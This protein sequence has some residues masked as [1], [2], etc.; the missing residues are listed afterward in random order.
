MFT[1]IPSS[2]NNLMLRFTRGVRP[3]ECIPFLS[4]VAEGYFVKSYEKQE[5]VPKKALHIFG[6]DQSAQPS[7]FRLSGACRGHYTHITY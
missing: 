1:C 2:A 4:V 3:L 7:P 5:T 6:S